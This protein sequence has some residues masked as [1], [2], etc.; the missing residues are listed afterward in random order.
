MQ[1][2]REIHATVLAGTE[3]IVLDVD[4]PLT[5]HED[6]SC[7]P[8]LGH[9]WTYRGVQCTLDGQ[10]DNSAAQVQGILRR[11]TGHNLKDNH[12]LFKIN[13]AKYASLNQATHHFHRGP[14]TTMPVLQSL[15]QLIKALYH[16]A[17]HKCYGRNESTRWHVG[18]ACQVRA[19]C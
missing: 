15:M 10:F 19:H 2:N 17:S 4:C 3:T 5:G 16:G 12:C 8:L 14:A 13:L 18:A 6:Q 9:G 7:A 11:H 1:Y